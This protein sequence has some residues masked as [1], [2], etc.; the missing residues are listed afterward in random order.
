LALRPVKPVDT[1][2]AVVPEP[3]DCALVAVKVESVLFVPHSKKAVVDDPLGLTL[4]LSVAELDA[5]DVA[6][7]VVTVARFA[8]VVKLT[9]EPRWVPALFWPTTL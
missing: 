7:E 6:D 9:M 8:L 1:E 3:T 5:I 4:P 2:T